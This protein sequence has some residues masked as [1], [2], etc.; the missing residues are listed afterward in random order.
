MFSYIC[1]LDINVITHLNSVSL[2][3]L[4]CVC[5]FDCLAV[6][7]SLSPFLPPSACLSLCF[8]ISVSGLEKKSSKQEEKYIQRLLSVYDS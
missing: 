5:F 1:G 8:S 7:L 3:W 6:P 2:S 4:C